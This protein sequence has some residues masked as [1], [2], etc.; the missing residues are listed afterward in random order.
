MVVIIILTLNCTLHETRFGSRELS[1]GGTSPQGTES[2]LLGALVGLHFAHLGT[3]TAVW[4]WELMC[5]FSFLYALITHTDILVSSTKSTLLFLR[6]C[7]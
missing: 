2:H 7:L 3:V 5:S 4:S 6:N 1:S